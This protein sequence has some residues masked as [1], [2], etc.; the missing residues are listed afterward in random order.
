MKSLVKTSVGGASVNSHGSSGGGTSGGGGGGSSSTAK[1]AFDKLS[2]YASKFFDWIEV[3]LDRLQK[4]IDSNISKAESKLNDKR[5]SSATANY[6]SAVGNTYT[7]MYT[8]QKGRDKYL[9]TANNYL[10]KAISLGAINKK[11]A[12][13]IKTRVADGSI[14]ISRYSSDIQTVIST[15]KDWIDKAK[16]CTT[17]MQ[18]LHDSLRT[19]AEDLKKVSDAQRDATVS[20]AETKQTIATGGVQ[21]TATA[22]NSSL[23]Y[24]NSVLNTKNSA[25]YTA[26]KSANSNVNKFAKSATSALNKG[27]IKKNTKYN[28]TLNSIKGYI[29]KRVASFTIFLYKL[30]CVI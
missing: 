6:M 28:A 21:N 3:R 4:K 23:G 29:K 18:T 19:Y 20:I 13:E 22:K 15:Y 9:N 16:D 7:K 24:N 12:K 10:N 1:T 25:Y 11:L 5:Y 2:D 14:N 17:A 27:K 30:M 8:E 26:A